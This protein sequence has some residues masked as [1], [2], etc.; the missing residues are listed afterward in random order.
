MAQEDLI[1]FNERSEE[2]HKSIATSG[3]I[4]SGEARRRKRDLKKMIALGWEVAQKL[5]LE[6]LNKALKD[7]TIDPLKK[8]ALLEAKK[9]IEE[10]GLDIAIPL[11]IASDWSLPSEKRL[12]ALNILYEHEH[13]KPKQRTE[14]TG[15][16]G[17][18]LIAPTI[19]DDI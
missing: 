10:T 16:D 11:Q 18:D 9:M 7:E 5:Q 19:K 12:S 1:P 17:K 14:L 8:E 15:A 3:G 4:A 6:K 2:E 13:G